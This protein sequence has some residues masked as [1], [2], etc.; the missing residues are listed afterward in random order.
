M[1][2]SPDRRSWHVC[3]PVDTERRR[4]RVWGAYGGGIAAFTPQESGERTTEFVTIMCA[5]ASLVAPL[6]AAFSPLRQADRSAHFPSE[7]TS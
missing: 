1:R 4:A 7:G 2:L 6:E 5:L 3:P